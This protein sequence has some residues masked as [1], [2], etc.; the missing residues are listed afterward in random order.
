M[1]AF[2]AVLLEVIFLPPGP[3]KTEGGSKKVVLPSLGSAPAVIQG[4]AGGNGRQDS[5]GSSSLQE[6]MQVRF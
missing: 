2:E 5:K 6:A 4:W 3:P 1:V